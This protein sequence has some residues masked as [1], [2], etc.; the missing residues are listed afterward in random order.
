M[1]KVAIYARVSTNK[2]HQS[3]EMQL[4]A[5]RDYCVSRGVKVYREYVDEGISGSKDS[6]PA[7]NLLMDD[8]RK[9]KFDAV[10][11]W[12]FDRFARS[13]RHLISALEE[14]KA[15]GIDFISYSE[16]I[17]TS[18]SLGKAVFT[19][20][21]AIGE[22]ERNMIRERVMAGLTNAKKKG[23]RLGRPTVAY[24]KQQIVKL[25]N[26]GLSKRAVAK[27]CGVSHSTVLRVLKEWNNTPENG[28][29]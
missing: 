17:D 14:F 6:R 24:D 25:C 10:I 7:L 18:T 20:V 29:L 16:N 8:A 28:A 26:T 21:A 1:S 9:R 2:M 5:L 13:T 12:K 19:I 3:P 4:T 11:V 27:Q 22:L 23:K 15:L